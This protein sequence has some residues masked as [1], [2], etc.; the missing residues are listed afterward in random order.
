[1]TPDLG[2]VESDRLQVSF[3]ESPRGVAERV[4]ERGQ[5]TQF[6]VF[7]EIFRHDK[8]LG[9][10]AVEVKLSEREFG[11]C[12]GFSTRDKSHSRVNP[13]PS[14]CLDGPRVSQTPEQQ[15][16]MAQSEGRQYWSLMKLP[17][18][19]FDPASLA[20]QAHCPFRHGLY[21]M[22]RN[23]VALDALRSMTSAEW[24]EFAV[25]VHPS[26]RLARQLPE[27]VA[28]QSDAVT[29]FRELTGGRGVREWDPTRVVSTIE[30]V[31]A[32]P[33]GWGD[34]MRAKYLLAPDTEL[35]EWSSQREPQPE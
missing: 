6:D 28:G 12:R 20:S 31:G 24:C 11:G 33:E 1:M 19:S 25:C 2:V 32:A 22:M 5:A 7:F 17:E 23:R 3:E 29:A 13:D 14:R 27:A 10:I 30:A 18:S 16:F 8:L 35:E 9:V 4:G 34:W 21:Q 15:C 26:N